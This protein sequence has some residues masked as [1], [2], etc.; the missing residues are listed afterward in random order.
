MFSTKGIAMDMAA[1]Q[2]E[3][4][5]MFM[6]P[7][8]RQNHSPNHPRNRRAI[9]DALALCSIPRKEQDMVLYG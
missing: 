8:V 5:L 4:G 6:R 9:I 2:R 7:S 3:N 1:A